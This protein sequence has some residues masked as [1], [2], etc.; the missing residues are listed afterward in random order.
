MCPPS[1]LNRRRNRACS[2]AKDSDPYGR[3]DGVA[4]VEAASHEVGCATECCMRS[5][6]GVIGSPPPSRPRRFRRNQRFLPVAVPRSLAQTGSSSRRFAPLQS[7]PF[8]VRPA[9]PGA[10]LLPWG[11]PSLFATPASGVLATG[12]HSRRAPSS[13]FLTPSTVYSAS[14]LV[15]L[16][17]PTATSRVRSPGASPR[18]Q[19]SRLVGV[20]CPLVVG[21]CP[22]PAVAHR[23]HVHSPRPQGFAPCPSPLPARRCYPTCLL[24]PL[25]SF[26]SSR[27]SLSV[28]R[29]RLHASCRSWPWSWVR[30]V[31]PM[32]GLQRSDPEP[33]LPLSRLP[34]CSRFATFCDLGRDRPR[35]VFLGPPAGQCRPGL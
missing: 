23:R 5:A 19:P 16:F 26:P 2:P 14:G 33:G 20:S 12:F 24:A 32:T 28:S 10:E 3:L 17:H 15:G 34:T 6:R 4:T 29:K 1:G 11:W 18:A 30:R 22:L 7:P 27:F 9:P 21:E 8:R 31:V 25:L 35:K 13:A